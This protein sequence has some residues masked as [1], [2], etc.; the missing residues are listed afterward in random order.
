MKKRITAIILTLCFTFILMPF[1]VVKAYVAGPI[2]TAIQ[3]NYSTIGYIYKYNVSKN[4]GTNVDDWQEFLGDISSDFADGLIMYVEFD[5][6]CDGYITFTVDDLAI[7]EKVLVEGNNSTWTV[8]TSNETIT[9]YLNHSNSFWIYCLST[10][11][12]TDILL[13]SYNAVNVI[14]G[15]TLPDHYLTYQVPADRIMAFNF[16]LKMGDY[17]HYD[18]KSSYPYINITSGK[19]ISLSVSDGDEFYV[20]Y[21]IPSY[22]PPSSR[23]LGTFSA[24][25]SGPGNHTLTETQIAPTN[26]YGF[27]GSENFVSVKLNYSG[28]A[29]TVTFTCQRN[30]FIRPI[31]FG[32]SGAYMSEETMGIIG[33]NNLPPDNT[34]DMTDM[35]GELG[36]LNDEEH[37]I[38]SDFETDL[39]DFNTD[40][41]L[42]DYDFITDLTDSNTYFK[43]V[44]NDVFTNSSS[45]RAFWVIP[46]ILVIITA[47]LGR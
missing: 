10:S 28:G 37:D 29:T 38:L 22:G 41:D 45:V 1:S 43:M 21:F 42:D 19:T 25:Y 46:L 39:T 44:L 31:Y 24:S 3:K 32:K 40:M 7:I 18:D 35:A 9:V 13:S 23:F 12:N 5:S 11:Y 17:I 14:N 36:D 47:L 33:L 15:G 6:Y 4:N 16:A 20:C 26:T 8:N 2:V 30:T 34:E 27:T